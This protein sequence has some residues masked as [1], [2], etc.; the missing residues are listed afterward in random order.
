MS[1]I[2]LPYR[3]KNP[4]VFTWRDSGH[5]RTKS[6]P[7]EAS[8]ALFAAVQSE[9]AAKEKAIMKRTKRAHVTQEKLVL[10]EL[11]ERYFLMAHTNQTTIKQA[12]YHVQPI[13]K[14]LGNRKASCLM[15]QDIF[16][17]IEAQ[18]IYGIAQIT[19]NRRVSILRAALNW[20]VGQ[21][22]LPV[23][24]LA[25]LRLPKASPRRNAPPTLQE[26]RAILNNAAPHVQRVVI[27]GLC[28]GA[29]IGPSELFK[30]TWSDVDLDFAMI[31]MPSADKNNRETGRDVPIRHDILPVLAKWQS[32][33]ADVCPFVIHWGGHPVRTISRAWK[34]ALQRAHI[35]RRIRPYDLR[36]AFA[37]YSLAGG[38]DLKTVA[39]LMGHTDASMILKTYQHVQ[40]SQKRAAVEALPNILG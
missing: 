2:Y 17:F 6:F 38:A 18:K 21:A 23:N 33:D 15:K 20:G 30:L 19:I 27:L 28:T 11:I 26:A 14:L 10:S 12:R 8:A 36:H 13:L 1:I 4:W 16:N 39:E 7:D 9:L 24:P 31:R 5:K 25:D 32:A 29:R 22:L 37:T 3:R 40:N 35:V 34:T